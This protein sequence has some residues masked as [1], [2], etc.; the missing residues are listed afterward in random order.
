MGVPEISLLVSLFTKPE[1]VTEPAS[2]TVEAAVP[3][4]TDW[5]SA[6]T[7]TVAF[8]IVTDDD[9]TDPYP[10]AENVKV[11]AVPAFPFK[12]KDEKSATPFESVVAVAF[13]NV[14]EPELAVNDAVT[15]TPD[16]DAALPAESVSCT[17]GAAESQSTAAGEY[18]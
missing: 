9:V 15:V 6:V 4:A 14:A 10:V 1:Y 11:P 8:P 13:D 17:L 2:V 16:V 12:I 5:S 7:V 18:V 3:K